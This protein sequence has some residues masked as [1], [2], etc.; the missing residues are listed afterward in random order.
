MKK[1]A[2]TLSALLM[3]ATSYAQ[4]N[5]ITGVVVDE[6]GE[7]LIGATIKP[8][9][10]KGGTVT[11]LNGNFN[12]ELDSNTKSII[13]SFVGYTPKVIKLHS[14]NNKYKVVLQPDAKTIK[15]VVVIG[16]GTV[17][18]GDVT[19]SISKVNA[20]NIED[21]PNTN[22]ASL[23]Q[24][25]LAGVEIRNTSGAPGGEVSV[26]I[27]GSV[28]LNDPEATGDF[29]DNTNPLYVVDGIPMDESFELSD[30]EAHDIASVE[31]LKD[32]SSSAIYG[33]RGANGV[34]LVTTK[35]SQK[36]GKFSISATAN[37]SLQQVNRSLD[38]MTGNEWAQ[39]MSKITDNRYVSQYGNMGAQSGDGEI[40][41]SLLNG[42]AGYQDYTTYRGDIRWSIPG[43][44]G[45]SY[46]DWQKQMFRL[47]PQQQYGLSASGSTRQG[48]YRMSINYTD[49]DGIIKGTGYQK[50][51]VSLAGQ[52]TVNKLTL[53]VSAAPSLAVYKGPSTSGGS[54]S[55]KTNLGILTMV[56]VAEDEAGVYTGSYPYDSYAWA[57]K[58][59]TN[60]FV[61]LN[62]ISRER[63]VFNLRTSA[64]LNIDI[65]KGLKARLTGS[66]NMRHEARRNFVPSNTVS[67]Y[68]YN[69]EGVNSSASW[70]DKKNH[71]FTLQGQ[72][73]YNKK[74]GKHSL[75]AMLGW[76]VSSSMYAD[77]IRLD[78]ENFIGDGIH[79]FTSST[80]DITSAKNSITTQSRMVSYYGRAI[81]NY[82]DRYLL[83]VSLRRDGSSRFGLNRQ[84]GTFPAFSGAWRMSNE[85]FWPENFFIKSAKL[86]MSYGLNGRNNIRTDAIRTTLTPRIYY[87]GEDRNRGYGLNNMGNNDLGWQKV[88][89]WDFAIDLG[90]LKNRLSF[91]IDYY[92]KRTR[93]LLYQLSL[94]AISGYS[95]AYFNIGSIANKGWDFEIRSVNLNKP[96]IW[97]TTLNLGIQ[98]SKA[99][100][101]GGNDRIESGYNAR[102]GGGKTQLLEVGSAVGDY[103]LY[104]AIGVFKSQDE[105]DNYPHI[106]SATVGSIKLRDVD[107]DGKITSNDRIHAG[108]PRPDVTFGFIN[109]FQWKNWILNMTVTGQVGGKIF[110]ATGFTGPLDSPLGKT[111]TKNMMSWFQDMFYS[112]SDPGN[113]SVPCVWNQTGYGN[114][115]RNLYSSDYVKLQNVT[116]GYLLKMPKKAM[117]KSLTVQL[118][119]ENALQWDRYDAGYS[120]EGA[121]RTSST[122][123]Y[124]EVAYPMARTYSVG[125]K[126]N[127]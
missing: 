121:I 12:M 54:S 110:A 28:S 58:T 33:S 31:V 81:Y 62:Y 111:P 64:F 71:S 84:W 102:G 61:K 83:N 57:S 77:D 94:P 82:N 37:F 45:I 95:K 100:N 35:G 118:S 99:L 92:Y 117:V 5:N 73:D 3:A 11:D 93:N 60:A 80:A 48:N 6:N 107:G 36:Q 103:Y 4:N 34:I 15:D 125:L 124:D 63:Q 96:L 10:G 43:H 49:Q 27:R 30:L 39:W 75:G 105:L 29:T 51:S 120:P 116:L 32:A 13:V 24:G 104:D 7:E 113:G 52:T 91:S 86:R 79:S 112:E 109:N 68:Y 21:R 87:F 23:L 74:W 53:G 25:Q 59:Q 78:A 18:K 69:G 76:S 9:N 42:H 46:I 1:Y 119:I 38:V 108:N 126:V 16:Y 122:S 72:L 20:E 41:K 14:K 56:P 26:N 47:A 127:L 50:V 101:L 106:T 40:I 115:T 65:M 88:D 22:V 70:W 98:S 66:W 89:S 44:P 2:I 8:A 123:T 55:D 67:N 85:S 17:K 19:A 90:M 114:T 97:T